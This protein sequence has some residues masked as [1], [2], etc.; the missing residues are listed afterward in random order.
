MHSFNLK[1]ISSWI[2][3]LSTLAS[4]DSSAQENRPNPQVYHFPPICEE[5][6]NIFQIS[7][8]PPWVSKPT[9]SAEKQMFPALMGAEQQQRIAPAH[10]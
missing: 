2:T 10:T 8:A 4:A 1:P 6:K 7:R 9:F 5:Y 3:S